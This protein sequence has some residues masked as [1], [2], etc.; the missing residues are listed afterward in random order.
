MLTIPSPPAGKSL[1][2]VLGVGMERVGDI[3]C[4]DP[5]TWRQSGGSILGSFTDPFS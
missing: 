5:L 4:H 2:G 1:V 3:L